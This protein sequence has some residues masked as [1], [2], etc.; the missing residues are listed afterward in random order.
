MDI[1]D[2]AERVW[3]Q[4]DTPQ[5]YNRGELR[6]DG[7]HRIAD[8]VWMWP[9]FGNVY[10]FETGDGLLMFDTGS[11]P[12]ARA[13]FDAVRAV[14]P[15]EPVRYAVYSHGHNDHVWGTTEFD[16]EASDAGAAR[17]IVVAHAAVVERFDRYVLTRGYNTVIN[18]RQFQAP[19]LQWPD[20]FRYPDLTYDDRMTLS[21][22]GLVVELSHGRGETDDATVAW[23]PAQ[24]IA[25]VGD[26]FIWSGPNAGNP[27][28]VQRFALDWAHKLRE[29]A[30]W[31]PQILLPGH[32]LPVVGRDRIVEAL[33]SAAEYLEYLH[34]QTL[35]YLN[36]GATV[37]EA[38]HSIV[39]PERFLQKPYLGPTYDEPE[40]VIR[41]IWRLYGGWWDADPSTLKPVS[42][43]ELGGEIAALAGGGQVLAD[44]A[45][46]VLADGQERLAARLIQLASDAEPENMAVHA[47]RSEIFAALK[48][49]ATSTMSKGVYAWA[50]AESEAA[51]HGKPVLDLV[52]ENARGT[53]AFTI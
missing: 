6:R 11:R 14:F 2:Y 4:E 35:R 44:R 49:T 33:T 16:R 36:S 10:L 32:G 3:R 31:G 50:V 5:A 20:D 43:A 12:T 51:L 27:Q 15:D 28:K 53:S 7:L 42:R 48:K 39:V 45:R 9:A 40:F 8:G 22:G 30:G 25:C 46:A 38:I 52:R 24:R 29:V 37:D 13:L 34:E 1:L 18:Q 26:F 47:A 19:D 23:F 21:L 41:N 17:P